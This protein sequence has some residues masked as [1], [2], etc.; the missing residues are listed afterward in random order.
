[1][2]TKDFYTYGHYTEDGRL[3]Y[4]GKG[5]GRRA[6]S[7]TNRNKHWRHIVEKHGLKVE[8]F[9]CWATEQ[10]AFED[11]R[12]LIACFRDGFGLEL[13]NYTDGGEGSSGYKQTEEQKAKI[14][15]ASKK[16]WSDPLYKE[17]MHLRAPGSFTEAKKRACLL[18]AE[19]GRAKLASPDGKAAAAKKNSEKSKALWCD[20]T[21]RQKMSV[22]HKS[23]WTGAKRAEK[24]ASVRGR[25]R[26][27]DGVV[28]RNVLP[29]EVADLLR[30][31]WVRG[32]GPN[33]PS[34]RPKLT[35]R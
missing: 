27:T 28:E 8:I 4:V 22:R 18:N 25:V 23:L 29:E 7:K 3:F 6:Y 35:K 13:C 15:A 19:K 5:V 34:K 11:E 12:F 2:A 32:R 30:V 33:S 9:S 26:M 20:E 31:G 17:K 21:F 16:N 24:S 10:E 14:S 1:M